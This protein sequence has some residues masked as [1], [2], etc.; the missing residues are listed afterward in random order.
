MLTKQGL[1]RKEIDEIMVDNYFRNALDV[2]NCI[3]HKEGEIKIENLT[4]FDWHLF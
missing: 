2:K 3:R 4:K 1:R